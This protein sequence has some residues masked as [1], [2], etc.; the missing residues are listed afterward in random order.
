MISCSLSA[1]TCAS[2]V[3]MKKDEGSVP[4]SSL[5]VTAGGLVPNSHPWPRMADT[6]RFFTGKLY[7]PV[8]ILKLPAEELL[9]SAL[10]RMAKEEEA[11]G[12]WKEG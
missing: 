7:V 10:P 1:G 3:M 12:G 2:K 5:T 9:W 6:Q 11:D 8:H 4:Q